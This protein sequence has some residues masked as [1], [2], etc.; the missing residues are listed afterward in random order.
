MIT[1]TGATGHLG[2]LVVEQLLDRGVPAAGIVA[3]VRAPEK[4]ADLA[5]RG[6]QVREADYDRPETLAAALAGTDR[7]LL[8]SGNELGQRL[9]QH[10]N[11]VEAARSAGVSLLAY[12]SIL[13][14]DT[15]SVPLGPEHK[16]TEDL[17]RASGLPY[18]LLRNGWY[19]EN[20]DL[21][22]AVAQGV[23]LGAAGEGRV[24]A[25][26]RADFAAAAVAVLTGDGHA[27][28][29]YELGGDEAFTL[30]ELAAEVTRQSGTEVAYRDLPVDEYARTLAGFGLPEPVARM[31][32]DSDAGLARGD[33]HTGT[34][35][36]SRLI[37]RPTTP[38]PDA[39]AQHL[40]P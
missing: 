4:A 38:L 5:A 17:V 16:A 8:V 24:S 6:V 23:I 3:A 1:V 31:L 30:A 40:K 19:L 28:K 33:L 32:A 2:R 27:G 7:L 26:T 9:R 25:A 34:G 39:V 37:A 12:T 29:V 13:A 22:G 21:A 35:D 10:G 15:T 20:Y 18:V 11:V 14:A 36:L